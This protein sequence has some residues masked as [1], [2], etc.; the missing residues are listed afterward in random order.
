[1]CLLVLYVVGCTTD[2][3]DD[4]SIFPVPPIIEEEKEATPPVIPNEVV[5]PVIPQ[6]IVEEPV[7]EE[8]VVEEPEPEPEPIE[9]EEEGARR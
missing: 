1:M 8:P 7:V 5:P 2:S 3:T 6:P 4:E 9:E